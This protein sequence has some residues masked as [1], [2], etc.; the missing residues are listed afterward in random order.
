[1]KR[2]HHAFNTHEHVYSHCQLWYTQ[3]GC[4]PHG[5]GTGWSQSHNSINFSFPFQGTLSSHYCFHFVV[6]STANTVIHT[7]WHPGWL[8]TTW[9]RGGWNRVNNCINYNYTVH[10][11]CGLDSMLISRPASA[12]VI[13]NGWLTRGLAPPAVWPHA[14]MYMGAERLIQCDLAAA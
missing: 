2:S 8:H 10:H 7:Q 14:T 4:S 9:G 3:A 13:A 11:F 5:G 12:T 6:Y 1:M